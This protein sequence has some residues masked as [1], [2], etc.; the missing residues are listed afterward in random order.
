MTKTRSVS[1]PQATRRRN[2][3]HESWLY[4]QQQSEVLTK[5]I[6]STNI[7]S[8]Y[9]RIPDDELYL[10]SIA[11]NK[12]NN[13]Q[14][15]IA[16]GKTTS[17]LFIY[18]VDYDAMALTHQQT[19]SLPCIQ[20]MEWLNYDSEESTLLT[21]HKNGTVHIVSIP[22]SQSDESASVIKRFNHKKHFTSERYR[23]LNIIKLCVPNW[24]ANRRNFL[25]SCN[26]NMFLWDMQHRSDLPI[27]KTQHLGMLSFDASPSQN[28]IVALCGEFGIALNDLRAAVGTP[29]V[30]TPRQQ[31][32]TSNCIKWA[33]Y[34]SNVL[35]ASHLDGSVRL[36]DIR[37]QAS[38]GKLIGHNDMITCLEWSEESSS[39]LYTGG[40]D[41]AIIHWDL[42]MDEDLSQCCLKEGLDSVQYMGER[43]L[44]DDNDIYTNL[45][46]RQCGTLIPAAKT[47]VVGMC[48]TNSKILSIDGSAFLGL[49][50]KRGA[51][52]FVVDASTTDAIMDEILHELPELQENVHTNDTHSESDE[53]LFEHTLECDLSKETTALNS[54]IINTHHTKSY[55][56]ANF[57]N[58]STET[59]VDGQH[60]SYSSL[61][62]NKTVLRKTSDSTL[63]DMDKDLQVE[64]VP[65]AFTYEKIGPLELTSSVEQ[66]QQSVSI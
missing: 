47:S 44:T 4:K 46:K 6:A 18:D 60:I 54:P 20:S 48:S 21:G 51:D 29:S 65:A 37:A 3:S 9:W 43:F 39:D 61:F 1:A 33:P 34:D 56:L 66:M 30:F 19:I 32:G 5:T 14:V 15:A 10:T 42:Q 28:G 17:N 16:S 59:L 22:D 55:S 49:H 12:Q 63:N 38:F 40:K 25:S 2:F 23:N 64:D 31:L 36:W 52:G 13:N 24:I 50:D 58:G 41:G 27:L 57:P 11:V 7:A 8:N 35:A 62:R 53:S 26:Q 45:Q